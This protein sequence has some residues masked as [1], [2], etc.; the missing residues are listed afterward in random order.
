[1]MCKKQKLDDIISM[2]ALSGEL[3]SNFLNKLFL[4][5]SESV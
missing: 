3:S 5:D 4:P 1:M 2:M